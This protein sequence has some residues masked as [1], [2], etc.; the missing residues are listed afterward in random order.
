MRAAL[1]RRSPL[2]CFCPSRR[3]QHLQRLSA[4]SPQNIWEIFGGRLDHKK[5]RKKVTAPTLEVN[6]ANGAVYIDSSFLGIRFCYVP[7]SGSRLYGR[8]WCPIR[9]QTSM[10]GLGSYRVPAVVLQP[11]SVFRPALWPPR[12]LHV[13]FSPFAV[14]HTC[15]FYAVFLF[16]V[17]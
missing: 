1:C 10:C 7:N 2:Q 13:R 11:P 17:V 4:N 15:L 3:G 9:L 5:G 14:R 8:C 6:S 12:A 16:F